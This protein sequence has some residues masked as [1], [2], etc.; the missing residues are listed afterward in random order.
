[1]HWRTDKDE[2]AEDAKNGDEVYPQEEGDVGCG[3]CPR[4]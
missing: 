1:M 2:K 4:P 3:A